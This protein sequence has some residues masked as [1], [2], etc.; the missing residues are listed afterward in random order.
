MSSL[1]NFRARPQATVSGAVTG[2]SAD[3]TMAAGADA[4]RL[5][6]IGKQVVYW[7][8]NTGTASV[9]TDTPLLP[10]SS[11]LFSVPP[12]TTVI[13]AIAAAAGSTLYVT[14]GSGN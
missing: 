7:R 14:P 5:T 8:V 3:I 13:A 1:F 11:E 10:N 4:V 6:N 2:V 12:A 9:T